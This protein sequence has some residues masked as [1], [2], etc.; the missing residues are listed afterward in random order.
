M[1]TL[2][3]MSQLSPSVVEMKEGRYAVVLKPGTDDLKHVWVGCD[4]LGDLLLKMVCDNGHRYARMRAVRTYLEYLGSVSR[5]AR[6]CTSPLPTLARRLFSIK[7]VGG[8]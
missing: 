7:D 6:P 1:G 3:T 8:K 4:K 5:W 2:T